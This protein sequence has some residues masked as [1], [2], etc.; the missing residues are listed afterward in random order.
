MEKNEIFR[1]SQRTNSVNLY[2]QVNK[3]LKTIVK[4]FTNLAQTNNEKRNTYDN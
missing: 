3:L 4:P 2:A 1:R